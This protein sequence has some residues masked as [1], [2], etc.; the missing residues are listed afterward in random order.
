MPYVYR[1]FDGDTPRTQ[2]LLPAGLRYR[3]ERQRWELLNGGRLTT[4]QVAERCRLAEAEVQRWEAATMAHYRAC[5][6]QEA[7]RTERHEATNA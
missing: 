1:L 2:P 3:C 7:R 6:S 4:A 5:E